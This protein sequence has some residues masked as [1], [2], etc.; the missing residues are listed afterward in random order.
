MLH[1]FSGSTDYAAGHLFE[2]VD[3]YLDGRRQNP[4]RLLE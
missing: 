1:A 4:H 2:N 3:Q